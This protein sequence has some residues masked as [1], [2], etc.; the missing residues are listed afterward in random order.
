VHSEYVRLG[1]V[2]AAAEF[3]DL[4][5]TTSPPGPPH[6]R[7]GRSGAGADRAALER[8]IDAFAAD[9]QPAPETW[10]IRNSPRRPDRCA[11]LPRSSHGGLPP[12]HPD[13][14]DCQGHFCRMV[15]TSWKICSKLRVS[16]SMLKYQLS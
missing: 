15:Q 12:D 8:R 13:Y 1:G 5:Q 2:V 4:P 7:S 9:P 3:S 14:S 16:V 11:G 10:P 6:S